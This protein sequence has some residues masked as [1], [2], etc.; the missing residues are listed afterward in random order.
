M[1]QDRDSRRDRGTEDSTT[2]KAVKKKSEDG[3]IEDGNGDEQ[4]ET[5][6]RGEDPA[7]RMRGIG[8]RGRQHNWGINE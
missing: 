5:E 7:I 4:V 1:A 6:S 3:E 8:L 2:V